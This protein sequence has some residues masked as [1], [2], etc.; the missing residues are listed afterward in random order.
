MFAMP[1][2][3]FVKTAASAGIVVCIFV[4]VQLLCEKLF[5]FYSLIPENLR[6]ERGKFW[7][8]VLVAVEIMLYAIA[9]AIF[10]FW[11]YALLPFFSFRAGIG[12]AIFL[13]LFGSLPYA[14]GLALRL[15][16]PGG[17][18]IFTLFFNLIKLTASWATITYL[19]NS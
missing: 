14:L 7:V 12:V 3:L 1:I 19:V 8:F 4:I 15:K 13:Y 18:L 17:V 11:I 5:G 6:E 10:Y 9:P 16:I 2:G